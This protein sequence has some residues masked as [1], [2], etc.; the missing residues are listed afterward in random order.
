MAK[1]SSVTKVQI[2]FVVLGA[3]IILIVLDTIKDIAYKAMDNAG[4]VLRHKTVDIYMKGEWLD[5]ENRV[6]AGTQTSVD[7]K[8][9]HKEI[10]ALFCPTDAEDKNPRNFSVAFW[11]RTARPDVNEVDELTGAKGTWRCTRESKSFT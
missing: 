6:C 2:V 5:G 10:T 3:F 4:W 7:E 8:H 11:G 9:H 1:S